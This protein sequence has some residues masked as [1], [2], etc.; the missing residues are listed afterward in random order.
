MRTQFAA[1]IKTT[2]L[3]LWSSSDA[4]PGDVME[5]VARRRYLRH[6]RVAARLDDP[7]G[8]RIR[9]RSLRR[10]R[11]VSCTRMTLCLIGLQIIHDCV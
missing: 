9:H 5:I 10:S 8:R 4:C 6:S 7:S 3:V 11:H 1:P 2:P